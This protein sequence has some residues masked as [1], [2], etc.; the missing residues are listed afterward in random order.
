MVGRRRRFDPYSHSAVDIEV[1]PRLRL[2]ASLS[3]NLGRIGLFSFVVVGAVSHLQL[4]RP[5]DLFPQRRRR[6][7]F[8]INDRHY[9][10]PPA[11]SASFRAG[12][13]SA[14]GETV[15][16]A[17]GC[18]KRQNKTS[19]MYGRDGKRDEAHTYWTMEEKDPGGD[20]FKGN[21]E[22]RVSLLSFSSALPSPILPPFLVPI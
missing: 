2:S 7:E 5:F 13:I 11:A 18:V 6:T 20:V 17:L 21:G 9:C 1:C 15:A 16:L 14:R 12:D 10:S 3:R 4:L 19:G 8:Q 22:E